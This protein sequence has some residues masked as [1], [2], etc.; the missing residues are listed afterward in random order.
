MRRQE[1]RHWWYLGMRRISEALLDAYFRPRATQARILDAGCGSGGTTSWL[2]RWGCV[3]GLD[4][5]PEALALARGRGLERLV[6]G[7]VDRLPFADESFDLVTSFDVLYHLWVTD[8]QRALGELHR[9]LRPGGLAL[10]RVAA[11]DW[12]R[13]AH[14]QAV[15]TRHRYK[16]DEL[17][18]QLCRA[19][20]TIERM[21]YANCFLFPLAP[22]KRLLER[23]EPA[24]P[25]DLWQPPGPV[26]TLLGGLLG[27]EAKLAVRTGLPWG[28]S[29]VAVAR[30]PGSRP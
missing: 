16:R 24:G 3:T 6:R 19:G 30:R 12:L 4:L 22:V 14:D 7:S 26:N 10:V 20:F 1:D 29:V 28:L 18:A 13:G 11:H 27:L 23:T 17:D 2:R 25:A 9:V 5:M 8:D 21:T 15:L